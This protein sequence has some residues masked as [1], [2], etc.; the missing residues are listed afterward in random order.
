MGRGLSAVLRRDRD[1]QRPAQPAGRVAQPGSVEA[2]V[3]HRQAALERHPGHR[4]GERRDP[5]GGLRP[6]EDRM[7]EV[8]ERSRAVLAQPMA[9]RGDPVAFAGR[10]LAQRTVDQQHAGDPRVAMPRQSVQQLDAGGRP[11]DPD[12]RPSDGSDRLEQV[13]GPT[14]GAVAGRGDLGLA[15]SSRIDGDRRPGRGQPVELRTPDR[16]GQAPAGHHQDRGAG[17]LEPR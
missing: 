9:E 8:G 12:R 5:L 2:P 4:R 15:L 14:V 1:P 13:G 17:P 3:E 16:G 11:G 7:R 10:A 6:S